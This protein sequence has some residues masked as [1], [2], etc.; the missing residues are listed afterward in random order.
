MKEHIRQ[1]SHAEI[2][3]KLQQNVESQIKDH[4]PIIRGIAKLKSQDIRIHC[5][6]EEEVKQLR[7]LKWNEAY[8]GLTVHQPKY[9]LMI[10][11]IPT[12]L[13]DPN[14]LKNPEFARQLEYQ[15]KGSGIQIVGMKPMRRKHKNNAQYFSLA[16]FLTSPEAADQC[17][18]HGF[19]IN[20]QRFYP[21]KYTPQFQ[22]IQCYKCQK[23]G[24]H[25]ISCRS[26]HEICAKCDEHHPI[27]QCHNEIHKCANCKGEHPAWHHDCPNRINVIQNLITRKREAPSYFN[28]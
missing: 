12:D 22:L 27:F 20:H 26:L 6:M 14:D 13:I 11:G 5:N 24:H 2:T 21:E 18:K 25:A 3:A 1:Q 4:F 17:I 10:P 7:E 15:N 9:G 16:V 19:Y 23:Y 8:E 28:E